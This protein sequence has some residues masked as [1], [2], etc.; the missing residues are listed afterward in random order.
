VG[1][2]PGVDGLY[3][4]VGNSGHGFK[5]APSIGE[6]LAAQILGQESPIDISQLGADRFVGGQSTLELAYGPSARA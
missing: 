5:L 1:A 4:S 2:A 6:C 3:M